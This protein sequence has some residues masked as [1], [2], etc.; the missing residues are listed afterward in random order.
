MSNKTCRSGVYKQQPMGINS[1]HCLALYSLW[2]KNGFYILKTVKQNK[3]QEEICNRYCM[4]H[5]A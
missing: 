1:G 2:A 3:K 5:K 4:A